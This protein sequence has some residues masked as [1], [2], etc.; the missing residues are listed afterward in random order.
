MGAVK[1][2]LDTG[3]LVAL[4]HAGD[5]RHQS[6]AEF[7]QRF[8]GCFLTTEAVLTEAMALLADLHGGPPAVLD[9]FLKGGAVLVPQSR[10]SLR[11]AREL[12]GKYGDLPMDFADATL[13]AL[14]EEART[15]EV[16]TLDRRGFSV[17]QW[18]GRHA[19]RIHPA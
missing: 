10:N 4:L 12:L 17:Y 2:L 19:F 1:C 6:C 5:A 3:P 16:F 13:V 11:R 14:A 18:S 9:F 8:P 7:L 15:G